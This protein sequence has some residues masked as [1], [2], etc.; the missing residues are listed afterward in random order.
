VANPNGVNIPTV[1]GLSLMPTAKP[2]KGT[3]ATSIKAG[4]VKVP[5]A[6][7]S[8]GLKMPKTKVPRAPKARTS[9]VLRDANAL[10]VPKHKRVG[11]NQFKMKVKK[12]VL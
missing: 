7:K 8:G 9:A 12:G 1:P 10:A 6:K 2:A 5:K 4:V 3:K 11:V